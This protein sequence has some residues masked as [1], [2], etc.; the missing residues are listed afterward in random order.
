MNIKYITKLLFLNPKQLLSEIKEDL[1]KDKKNKYSKLNKK[2]IFI[3]GIPKSGTTLI[4]EILEQLP[5]VRINRSPLR[6]FKYKNLKKYDKYGYDQFDDSILDQFN[7]GEF[8]FLKT[9]ILLNESTVDILERKNFHIILSFRDIR[10]VMISRY[11]HIINDKNHWAHE[12]I[13]KLNK[14]DGFIR[15]L[16][17][18]KN[19]PIGITM[20]PLEQYYYWLKLSKKIKNSSNIS[21][22]W[23]EDYINKPKDFID[24]I[25]KDLNLTYLDS[26]KIENILITKRNSEKNSDLNIKLKRVGKNVSTFREGNKDSWKSFFDEKTSKAFNSILPGSIDDVLNN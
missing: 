11:F 2:K 4:E 24:K 9:H 14:K 7:D 17:S 12:E 22:L 18:F 6:N 25:L 23:Y 1:K 5:Y 13:S 19:N 3:A 16:Q 10:D 26:K 20:P 21:K 8:S 15:S